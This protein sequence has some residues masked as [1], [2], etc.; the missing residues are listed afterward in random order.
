MRRRS[1]G[2]SKRW[3]AAFAAVAVVATSLVTVGMGVGSAQAATNPSIVVSEV[4]VSSV[5]G[6]QATVGDT[7]TIS[8]SWDAS[9]ANPQAGDTFTIGLPPELRFTQP[10]PFALTGANPLDEIV[11]W[12]NCLT[13]PASGIATCTLTDQ[14][15]PY[16]E[17]VKGTFEFDVEAALDTTAKDV[18]FDLNGEETPVPLPGGGGIDDGIVISDEW[19]KSGTLNSNKWSMTWTINLPGSR[20]AGEDSVTIL[21][22]LSDNHVLCDPSN[23]KVETVRGS[24]VVNVTEIATAAVGPAPYDFSLVL[25]APENGFDPDVTYRVKYET[26]TPDG[27]IDPQGTIYE[28]EATIDVFGESSGIIGVGQ[29]WAF[30][31]QVNKQGS[32]LGG[33]DRNGKIGWTVTV[34]GDHFAGKDSF[35][36]TEALTGEHE[37]CADTVGNMRVFE[38]YGP[39]TARQREI[40]SELVTTTVSSTSSAFEVEFSIADGSDFVF[41]PSDYFYLIQYKTCATTDGL[42]NAGTVFGN[43]AGVDGA[44]DGSEA[45][46][47][48]RTNQKRGNINTTP[49]TIDGVEYLPQ[50]TIGWRITVPGEKLGDIASELIV[51]DV[52][53]GAHQVCVG[54]GGD[55]ASRLGLKVQ[56]VDQIQNGGL[57]TVDLSASATASLDTDT[58]TITIPQPTL[59]QPGGGELSGFSHE[60]Q[61]VITY[62]TCTTSGGMDAPGTGYGNA[63][64]VA[65]STYNQTVTQSNRGSGTGSGVARGSVTVVKNLA[66]TPGAEFVPDDAVFTVHVKEIDPDGIVQIEYD[67]Q[68]PVNGSPKSGLNSRGTG[69]TIELS[70]LTFPTVPGV[71][72][73]SPI[74]AGGTGVTPSADG[75]TAIADLEPA[76][77]IAVSLT[78]TAELGSLEVRKVLDGP[79]AG[80]VDSAKA[81]S[82]TAQIDVSALGAGIPAQPDRE[83]TVKAGQ[84]HTLTDLPVGAVVSFSE[85]L[86]A[87][88]DTLTW[89]PAVIDPQSIEVVAA[90][91]T[92]PA[93]ITV[94][95]RVE[96]TVGTFTLAKTVTGAQADNP[97]VPENVT[98]TARWN[99][100]GTPGEK[101]L[102]I[103]TDGTPV[104]FGEA[105]LIGTQVTLTETPLADG[106]S[107]AWGAPVWS[108]TGVTINQN[109]GIVTIG[110]D[111]GATV[112]LENSATT[113]QAGISVLKGI[114][115][116][117]AS[118]VDPATEFPV[119]ASWTDND[120]VE[121]S[122]TLT[123]NAVVP[124]SLGEDL[125][126]GTVV[127]ITEKKRPGIDTVVWGSI[128]IT[129]EGV[130]D[131]GNGSATITVS[132]QQGDVTLATV[133]NEANWAPGIFSLTKNVTGVLLS[134]T[135]VP[136]AVTVLASWVDGDGVTQSRETSVPTDGSVVPFGE[137]IPHNTEV[138]LSEIAPDAAG[139]FSWDRP[140]WDG[141]SVD[142]REDGTAVVTIGAATVA[143]VT[144]TNNASTT[145]GS[146][147]LVKTLTGDG[148]AKV[149]ANTA[150]P[151]TV[152][153]V[154]LLG[155]T[156]QSEITV[157]TGENAIIDGL[158]L[159]TE[160][161]IEE[162][163]AS[164]P[165]GVTWAG[166]QWSSESENVTVGDGDNN[167][168]V[169]V[170]VTGESGASATLTIENKFTSATGL[171][172]TGTAGLLWAGIGALVLSLIGGGALLTNR[173]RRTA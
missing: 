54:E 125:P 21:E 147:E 99:E 108:G 23:L 24:T 102:M 5:D 40:T 53:S 160:V 84:S 10:V 159:G 42:P 148:A 50:T 59:E 136:K 38:R 119:T 169:V 18:V 166:V 145:L 61:Y 124:T 49:V 162:G 164:L 36:L 132:D 15:V 168:A 94:T 68:V 118:E 129:G 106:S 67:L 104:S 93:V 17:L 110:R 71:V 83:F 155:D 81:Y 77:N 138:V 35:T 26:C 114:A 37:V 128:V 14:V 154:D 153:W 6:D 1:H 120:G 101:T 152:S 33:A 127:T 165:H 133:I 82:I 62:T 146:L 103:P 172:M 95:N 46:V 16:P 142:V 156:Q 130:E 60:Y 137:D 9:E 126:A 73:G 163:A 57:A 122:K 121:H 3:G 47:P 28:N 134:N 151:L 22:Q 123:I 20:M 2:G 48:G 167:Q 171:A 76:T 80:L 13:D 34:A 12:A 19:D 157:R 87:D 44:V 55:I 56:A 170:T 112:T 96:R 41:Q 105:L 45:T 78:N 107:I 65:G 58:V 131:A 74:F 8:G 149:P 115:G 97:A 64:E 25:I 100:G 31:G 72:F 116:A 135:D 90:H 139:S 86:P 11:A 32:V 92:E 51:T 113:S 140:E 70:E 79:A 69:W 144:L 161:R 89:A 98:V 27:L 141:D 109:T 30:T 63:A 158:P 29:D 150:F 66:D 39:S 75:T 88:D 52:L 7:L 173:R 43:T 143:E 117:A 4:S 91:V 85:A 111:A